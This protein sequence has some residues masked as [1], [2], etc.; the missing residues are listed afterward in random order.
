MA[1]Y[2]VQSDDIVRA[3]TPA[4]LAQIEIIKQEPSI[5]DLIEAQTAARA[6]AKSKLKALGLTEDEI[7]ALVG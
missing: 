1:D 5:I 6:S 2:L 4:E 3:A 7:A